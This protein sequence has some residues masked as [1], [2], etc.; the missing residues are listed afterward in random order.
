[1]E[2]QTENDR[3]L[4]IHMT[5]SYLEM[6]RYWIMQMHGG[7]A[8][9]GDNAQEKRLPSLNVG[10]AILTHTYVFSYMALQAFAAY[11]LEV[12]WNAPTAT[13]RGKYQ[14]RATFED[15]LMKDLGDLK[16]SLKE[17]CRQSHIEQIHDVDNQ[18][19]MDFTNVVREARNYFNHPKPGPAFQAQIGRVF[20]RNSWI[21]PV[22]VAER[23]IS[24]FYTQTYTP[25]PAWLKTNQELFP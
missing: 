20:E 24:H 21:F 23:I 22:D 3:H 8:Q 10:Y 19:W 13:L 16:E 5:Q 15:L 2:Q 18:L 14:H 1:M 4:Q 11:R 9:K 17:L 7:D 25:L 6:A 12:F